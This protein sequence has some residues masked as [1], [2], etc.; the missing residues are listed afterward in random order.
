MHLSFSCAIPICLGEHVKLPETKDIGLIEV[1]TVCFYLIMNIIVLRSHRAE[2]RQESSN[3]DSCSPMTYNSVIL[4]Y[5]A[6]NTFCIYFLQG[7]DHSSEQ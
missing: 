7:P 1:S 3:V 6:L 5:K 2:P 4:I